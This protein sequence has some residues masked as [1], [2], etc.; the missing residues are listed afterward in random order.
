MEHQTPSVSPGNFRKN[1]FFS[2]TGRILFLQQW[3]LARRRLAGKGSRPAA[4][5]PR[6]ATA[7]PA[8]R[9]GRA[10]ARCSTCLVALMPLR[11][12]AA[13]VRRPA[14]HPRAPR[15]ADRSSL[16]AVR[17]GQ[18]GRVSRRSARARRD[19]R[20]HDVAPAPS[21]RFRLVAAAACLPHRHR[22]RLARL[23]RVWRR[24]G[25]SK[26]AAP[27]LARQQRRG[28]GRRQPCL[29]PQRRL[30]VSRRGPGLGVR[31]EPRRAAAGA[32]RARG[33]ARECPAPAA[34]PRRL[35]RGRRR[36]GRPVAPVGAAEAWAVG[37]AG[38]RLG[39]RRVGN[40]TP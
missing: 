40:A 28:G 4:S 38:L 27:P 22:H 33:G 9:S 12:S 20:R 31:R 34:S 19:G 39:A 30:A 26:A 6:C 29:V 37:G 35:R 24:D 11:A 17:R 13:A 21:R 15:R 7:W 32:R 8:P 25:A 1:A 5:R 16:P 3:S 2:F 10:T 18:R 36:A 14:P 23:P